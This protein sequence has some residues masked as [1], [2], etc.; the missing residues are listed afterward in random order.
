MKCRLNKCHACCCYNIPFA[1]GELEKFA[2]KIVNPVVY[3]EPLGP[4]LVAF[5]VE[6]N[7]I[8]DIDKNKCPFLRDDY[9]CNI[10]DN[11]PDVCRKFG[12]IPELQC[13]YRRR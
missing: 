5:T 8:L 11:R 4:A 1:D 9:K 10:Y 7:N 3:T 2:D 13:E 12:E 6:I